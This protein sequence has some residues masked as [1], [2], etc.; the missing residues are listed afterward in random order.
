M[1]DVEQTAAPETN[2]Q[3][4][5]TPFSDDVGFD[6]LVPMDVSYVDDDFAPSMLDGADWEANNMKKEDQ[7]SEVAVRHGMKASGPPESKG[8]S[9]RSHLG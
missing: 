7:S 5:E 8:T 6:E 9:R 3:F 2:E 4:T 1:T